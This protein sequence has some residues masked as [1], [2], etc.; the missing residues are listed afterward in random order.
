LTTLR[1]VS[2]GRITIDAT[3]IYS[4]YYWQR[5]LPVQI[6]RI[7]RGGALL[8]HQVNVLFGKVAFFALIQGFCRN[9]YTNFFSKHQ[10]EKK[11]SLNTL[12]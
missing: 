7:L 11:S 9:I 6:R 10:Q 5:T 1:A 3:G 8:L 12:Y 4:V 2:H